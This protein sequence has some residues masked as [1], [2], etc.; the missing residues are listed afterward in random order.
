MLD[1]SS[2]EEFTY[3]SSR[4]TTPKRLFLDRM[5]SALPW[6]TLLGKLKPHYNK[7]FLP[8]LEV[9][10]RIAFLQQW[11]KYSDEE[12]WDAL[13][14]NMSSVRYFARVMSRDVPDLT[15][16]CEFRDW[17]KKHDLEKELL[18]L[19]EKYAKRIPRRH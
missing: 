12:L 11:F 14:E 8:P 3:L 5:E 2:F 16:I 17:L 13:Y 1:A 15:M 10:V 6:E 18:A 7:W 4:V 19:S 9:M